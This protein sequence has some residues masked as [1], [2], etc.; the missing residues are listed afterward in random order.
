MSK[1][2]CA[3]AV[4][5]ITSIIS[6]DK[7]KLSKTLEVLSGQYGRVDFI[8]TLFPF[9]Y[10][11][12]YAKEMGSTLVRRFASFE[13]LVR[14]ETLPDIKLWMNS[15]EDRFSAKGKRRVNIDPG[16]MSYAHII[17]A[18][19]KGYTHRPYLRNGIYAD[20][21]LVYRDG[22]FHSLPWTYPDYAEGE[23]IEMFN[24]IRAKYIIQMKETACDLT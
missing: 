15:I 24:K 20:L 10:T 16:Y 12:Y 23:V 7:E 4:K 5:L 8:S 19:G 6:G 17:L 21:T 2:K 1:P 22:T 11:D 14:P 9:S 3:E 13:L 18:T